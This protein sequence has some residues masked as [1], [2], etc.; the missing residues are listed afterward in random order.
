MNLG[1]KGEMLRQDLNTFDESFNDSEKIK[2]YLITFILWPFLAFMLAIKDFKSKIA[3]KV[4]YIF[5]I[6]YGFNMFIGAIGA[7]A[8]GYARKIVRYS[9]LPFSE[10]FNV[11]SGK[12]SESSIDFFE[13]F[14]SFLSAQVTDYYGF[15]FAIWAGIFGFFYLKSTSRLHEMYLENPGWNKLIVLSFF[16]FIMPITAVAGVRMWTAMWIFFYG[17]YQVILYRK[18]KY[19]FLTLGACLV[20]FSFMIPNAILV[21]F[22]FAGN[23]TAIYT[24]LVVLSFV[25]PNLIAPTFEVI[26]GYM[27]GGI[28]ERYDMYSNET[29]MEGRAYSYQD[30]PLYIRIGH[31]TIYYFLVS[32]LIVIGFFYKKLMNANHEKSLFNFCLLFLAFVN[33][34]KSIPSLGTRFQVLFYLFTAVYFMLYLIK[35]TESKLNALTIL[36][37]IPMFLYAALQFRNGADTINVWILNPILGLPFVT[38]AMALSDFLF[39]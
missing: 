2:Y 25:L 36:G 5:L 19:L 29:Y 12:Y 21:M 18:T 17:A 1:V 33:F 38:E 27:G 9:E 10:F 7:D 28:Q 8:E 26:S 23:R 6:Y 15:A 11:V 37:I 20:H 31:E 13:P 4:V 24:A 39:G 3:K 14:I 34:G 30:L 16:V 35:Q 22:Y 32:I